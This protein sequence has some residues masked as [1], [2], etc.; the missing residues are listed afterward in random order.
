MVDLHC[1]GEIDRA[2]E[3]M[4][5]T[6][7]LPTLRATRLSYSLRFRKREGVMVTVRLKMRKRHLSRVRCHLEV[8]LDTATPSVARLLTKAAW[9]GLLKNA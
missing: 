2:E 4:S 7:A 9:L 3:R 5:E 6:R 8:L 1:H